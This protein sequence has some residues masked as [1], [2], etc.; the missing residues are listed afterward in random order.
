MS[1]PAKRPGN[2][3]IGMSRQSGSV[4]VTATATATARWPRLAMVCIPALMCAGSDT[5]K[6]SEAPS[7]S[8]VVYFADTHLGEGSTKLLISLDPTVAIWIKSRTTNHTHAHTA[9]VTHAIRSTGDT[10]SGFVSHALQAPSG[11][12]LGLTLAQPQNAP[13]HIAPC[14]AGCNSS[15]TGYQRNDTNCYSV[16]DLKNMVTKVND[17][18]R[19]VHNWLSTY[20]FAHTHDR[21]QAVSTRA[22]G[23]VGSVQL[24]S[25]NA[26]GGV[27]GGGLGYQAIPL[28]AGDPR[29]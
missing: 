6:T 21:A 11:C 3:N 7:V 24:F 26:T 4:C 8:R 22:C 9:R 29:G 2:L 25:H 19:C 18:H 23:G 28:C 1:R 17:M 14:H 15:A 27:L 16:T 5:G 12:A 20:M 13:C 10:L